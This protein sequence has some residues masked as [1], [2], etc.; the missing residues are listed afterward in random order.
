MR[1]YGGVPNC[2]E[3][4]PFPDFWT[5]NFIAE[6]DVTKFKK[7]IKSPAYWVFSIADLKIKHNEELNADH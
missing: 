7:I 5:V 2:Y 4:P 6:N 1:E 3:E